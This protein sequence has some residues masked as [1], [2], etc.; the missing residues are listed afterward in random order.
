MDFDPI[1]IAW[2]AG[3]YEGEGTLVLN[4]KSPGSAKLNVGM[5]DEDVIRRCFEVA[6]CG[7]VTG[8]ARLYG[9]EKKLRWVWSVYR[10][11]DLL[12]LL[13]A[14]RPFLGQ[15][16]R[17]RVDEVLERLSQG[18]RR[19]RTSPCGTRT[20]YE[21]HRRRREPPC[22]ACREARSAYEREGYRRRKLAALAG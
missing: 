20:G 18:D 13:P 8:G 11:D 3:I 21:Q 9:G 16:R 6:R 15:R 10:R 22:Q 17:Q 14:L 1:G 19:L 2:L 5:T 4:R 7:V 12:R